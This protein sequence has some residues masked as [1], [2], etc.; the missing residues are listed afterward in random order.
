MSDHTTAAWALARLV[1]GESAEGIAIAELP[2][3]Y[4]TIAQSLVE[5]N[6]R[7]AMAVFTDELA[8]LPPETAHEIRAAVLDA[9][10]QSPVPSNSE[11]DEEYELLDH[12]PQAIRKPLTLLEGH[13]YAATWVSVRRTVRAEKSKDGK[14]VEHRKPV[15]TNGRALCLV[16]DDGV[17][18][19]DADL[20]KFGHWEPMAHLG[21]DVNLTMEGDPGKVW[22]GA[23]VKRYLAGERPDPLDVFRRLV[24]VISRFLDFDMSLASQFV[25]AALLACYILVSYLLDALDVVGYIWSNGEGGSGKS[26]LLH[27]VAELGFLG[28]MTTMGGTF[29]ALRD[30]SDYGAVLCFDDAENIVGGK[31]NQDKVDPDKRTLLLAGNRRGNVVPLK[32]LTPQKTWRTRY[33]S[34][35]SPRS[36]SATQLPDPLLA[37]RSIIVPLVRTMDKEKANFSPSNYAVWPHNR[38]RLIDDL[39]AMGLAYLPELPQ[40]VRAAQAKARLASRALEPWLGILGVAHWLTERGVT[41]LFDELEELSVKYQSERAELETFNAGLFA[42]R[43]LVEL[44]STSADDPLIVTT[45]NISQVIKEF[46]ADGDG[47]ENPDD[48]V[49]LSPHKIGHLLRQ[50]RIQQLPRPGGRGPR[51]WSIPRT[52]IRRLALSHGIDE[53]NIP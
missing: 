17:L 36:F 27:I 29:A 44:A 37:G 33:V 9:D 11:P 51:R 7:E 31:H 12:T 6:G 41:N 23:G 45:S 4:R 25:M 18:F 10:P 46:T 26:T 19:S 2:D 13:A 39:W 43:A 3:P 34:T 8:K 40:H 47:A 53:G 38:N 30:L 16:R 28:V 42:I 49:T 22:S 21:W 5:R 24:D 35:F 1:R 20:S 52:I 14:R 48:G 15:V 50:W 32:E